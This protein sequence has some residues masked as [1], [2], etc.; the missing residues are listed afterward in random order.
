MAPLAMVGRHWNHQQRVAYVAKIR[1]EQNKLIPA[2]NALGGTIVGRFTHA[3]AGLGVR[4]D[5]SKLDQIRA[6]NGVLAARGIADYQLDLSETVGFIGGLAAQDLGYDGT[7]VDVAVIDSGVDYTHIKLGGLGTVAGYNEAYCGD[8]S[9]AADPSNPACT[10]YDFQDTTGYF[11]D[12]QYGRDGSPQ[13]K[14]VGGWDWYGEGLSDGAAAGGDPNPIDFE[15]H[16][17]HVADII[18]GLESASGAGD[19]GVAPGVNIWT[20]TM[21]SVLQASMHTVWIM[22]QPMS[23]I[24][25]LVQ[26]MASQKTI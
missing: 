13:N 9:V 19:A 17:T 10:A 20:Q 22:T 25:R 14:V 26:F 1:A 5:A 15:G 4:I 16:G 7:G 18:G 21:A 12:P 8:A 3:S 2:I 24:C 11:G 23:S 6:M